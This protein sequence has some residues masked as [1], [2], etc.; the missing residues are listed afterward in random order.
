LGEETEITLQTVNTD[1]ATIELKNG[2]EIITIPV[3]DDKFV[4]PAAVNPGVVEWRVILEGEGPT[5]YSPWF[6]LTAQE[7]G[8]EVDEFALY[9]QGFALFI[10]CVGLVILQRPKGENIE[11]NKYDNTQEVSTQFGRIQPNPSPIEEPQRGPPLP[12]GGL[13]AGWTM[14]Q[15]EWYGHEW[16]AKNSGD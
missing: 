7:P 6:R 1:S 14:E 2:A 11:V 9:L 13:P 8:W 10:L 16:L 3:V 12:E 15:W 4:I 5:Q